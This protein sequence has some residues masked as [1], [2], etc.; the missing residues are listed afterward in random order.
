MKNWVKGILKSVKY[1]S[2]YIIHPKWISCVCTTVVE[3]HSSISHVDVTYSFRMKS[4]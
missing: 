2:L 4:E 1:I 3:T